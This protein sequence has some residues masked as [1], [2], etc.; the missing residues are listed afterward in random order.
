MVENPVEVDVDVGGARRA[1]DE[2]GDGI[3]D[4]TKQSIRQ[5]TVLAESV[6]KREAPEGSGRDRHLR[7]TVDTRFKRGGLR[8]TVGPRKRVGDENIL[9]AAILA[10]DPQWDPDNP[11]SLESLRAWTAAKWGDGSLAAAAR[12]QASLVDDG[13]ESA[14]NEFIADAFEQWVRRVEDLTGREIRSEIG[15]L[16][17][18]D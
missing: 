14:P 12:L 11:P 3:D 7:D 1:L 10:D 8:A 18:A 2:V 4:G 6:I 16:R 17:G 13:M 9:L 5:L 15:S